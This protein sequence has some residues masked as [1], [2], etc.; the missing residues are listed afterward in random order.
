MS[1]TL[2]DPLVRRRLALGLLSHPVHRN[3]RRR[4][5]PSRQRHYL[6]GY[7]FEA[8]TLLICLAVL[9]GIILAA[10]A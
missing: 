4:R 1:P 5:R 10:R 6:S 8:A 7:L 3:R 9:A 2:N